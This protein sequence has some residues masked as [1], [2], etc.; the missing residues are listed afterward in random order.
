[1][2][3]LFSRSA[4]INGVEVGD[5]LDVHLFRTDNH[6]RMY[7]LGMMFVMK[8]ESSY[9]LASFFTPHRVSL[10][11]LKNTNGRMTFVAPIV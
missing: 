8:T 10:L 3:W 7:Y 5:T 6:K 4:E 9:L 11:T 1:M 2:G